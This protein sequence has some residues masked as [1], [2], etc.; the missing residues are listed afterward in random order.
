[1][2]VENRTQAE[3]ASSRG[4][5]LIDVLEPENI[6]AAWKK[7]KANNGKP[8]IDGMEVGDFALAPLTPCQLVVSSSGNSDWKRSAS[9]PPHSRLSARTLGKAAQQTGRWFLQTIPRT[10]RGDPE[11]RG[12]QTCPRHTDGIGSDDPASDRSGAD[13]SLRSDLQ[14]IVI[15]LSA[16]AKRARCHHRD[17][18]GRSEDGEQVPCGGLRSGEVLRYS[19]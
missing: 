14:R 9:R 10:P 4:Y 8:G 7:V 16:D 3:T 12:W 17:G 2:S 11:G 18:V 19:R 5:T 15:W 1:M 13:T 6:A